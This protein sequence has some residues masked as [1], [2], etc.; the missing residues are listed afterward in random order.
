M[1]ECKMEQLRGTP[2]QPIDTV[3]GGWFSKSGNYFR[4]TMQE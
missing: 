2:A 3:T 1:S 4:A